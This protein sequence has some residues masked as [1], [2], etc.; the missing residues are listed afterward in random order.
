MHEAAGDGAVFPRHHP[1]LL[2]F[3]LVEG[4]DAL[5]GGLQRVEEIVIHL[6]QGVAQLL[7]AYPQ[8]L[9]AHLGRVEFADVFHQR[10][11]AALADCIDDAGYGLLAGRVGQLKTVAQPGEDFFAFGR[12]RGNGGDDHGV[13]LLLSGRSHGGD[14]CRNFP[15][16]S[17]D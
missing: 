17:V 14:G 13:P 10:L 9:D 12:V 5:N 16:I 8:L 3:P 6:I 15:R 2:L 1:G 7:V 11:V 4:V